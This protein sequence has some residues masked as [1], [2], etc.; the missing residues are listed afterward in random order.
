MCAKC[1][2]K[3]R[4]KIQLLTTII[5]QEAEVSLL[6]HSLNGN[7]GKYKKVRLMAHEMLQ[8]TKPLYFLLSI[9]SHLLFSTME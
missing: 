9:H 8:C 6:S 5:T 1:K 7:G 2:M 3:K 4:K